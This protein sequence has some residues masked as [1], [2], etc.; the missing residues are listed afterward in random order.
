MSIKRKE[1]AHTTIN[2][3]I[4]PM[5]KKEIQLIDPPIMYA[6]GR[7]VWVNSSVVK[8]FVTPPSA[9]S[10]LILLIKLYQCVPS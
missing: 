8:M 2:G 9:Q 3:K 4:M 10:T 7:S 1:G 5:K 6:A